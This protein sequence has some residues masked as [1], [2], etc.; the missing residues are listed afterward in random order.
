MRHASPADPNVRNSEKLEPENPHC[1]P[2]A[3]QP[4]AQPHVVAAWGFSQ[5]GGESAVA[6]DSKQDSLGTLRDPPG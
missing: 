6:V 4:R 5:W 3:R 1:K 2:N